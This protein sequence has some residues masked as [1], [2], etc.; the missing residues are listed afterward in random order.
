MQKLRDAFFNPK[1]V[2]YL[3]SDLSKKDII[4]DVVQYELTMSKSDLKKVS[5]FLK[6]LEAQDDVE[7]RALVYTAD[8]PFRE[9]F[10]RYLD[11][12]NI[13]SFD[14]DTK[15]DI[16]HFSPSENKINLN[17]VEDRTNVHGNYTTFF[18][19]VGHA[20][21]YY[22]G[23]EKGHFTYSSE[24]FKNSEGNSL[25]ETLIF[26]FVPHLEKQVEHELKTYEGVTESLGVY[27]D[28]IQKTD[29]ND[30]KMIDLKDYLVDYIV[31]VKDEEQL[32]YPEE[33][34]TEEFT[35][36]ELLVYRDGFR[37]IMD[38]V[39]SEKVLNQLEFFIASDIIGGL[40][41]N[42]IAGT[43]KHE[44]TY[45]I[46]EKGNIIRTPTL[47]YFAHMFAVEF[48]GD[49]LLKTNIS[50]ST[51]AL[52]PTSEV[53]FDQIINEIES[54]TYENFRIHL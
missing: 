21:D 29:M 14:L 16:P 47:E 54:G 19:E 52:F 11:R 23:F 35:E 13:G 39:Y 31:R 22:S 30:K 33:H 10:I 32:E 20:V 36:D 15:V 25:Y 42:K 24:S 4:M 37:D 26:D 44:D 40:T 6:P 18:H 7:I 43:A 12:F 2:D 41:G 45:Y 48:C 1:Y 34:Y 50:N 49:K 9:L 8:E 46:D 27:Y 53:C 28:D 5:K 51:G 38:S 3:I 17:I